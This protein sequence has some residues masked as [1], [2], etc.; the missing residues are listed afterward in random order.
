MN[1]FTLSGKIVLSPLKDD[2]RSKK[3]IY[4]IWKGPERLLIT[5]MTELHNIT[6]ESRKNHVYALYLLA[7]MDPSELWRNKDAIL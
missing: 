2:I 5:E 4:T 3:C 6:V 7:G 1:A